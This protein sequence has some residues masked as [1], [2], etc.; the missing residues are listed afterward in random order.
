MKIREQL[1]E[2]EIRILSKHATLSMNSKGREREEK[3]CDIRPCF[4]RD[5]DRILYSKSFRRLKDKTQV[6]LSPDGDHYRTRM[7]HTLEVSQ[8]ARTI[9]KALM[10]NE[11]LAEAIA[12]GHDL[13]HT[14]FGHAGERA[15][16][17]VNPGGFRHNEQSL[18]IVE[19]LEN[20]G[21]GLNLTWEVRDGILNHEMNLTPGTLEGKVVR[22]S[23]K[24]AYMHHDMDDAI[25]G[26]ILSEEDVPADLRRVI[27]ESKREWLDTFIHDIISNSMEKDNIQMSD[28]IYDAFHKLRKFMFERVYTNPIAKSQ[29][30]KVEDMIKTLYSYYLDH[31]DKIPEYLKKM[32]DEGESKE[33]AVCDYV[34]SMTDRYAVAVFEE[35]YVPRS[36]G[37]L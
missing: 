14:P 8:N 21:I 12:L 22:L 32:M 4:Q 24:I 23:D 10:L 5:R 11:D 28:E 1:E 6:F 35:I 19:K 15:L 31:I 36:W 16:N 7:T 9:A 2:R 37:V 34:S 29:E 33:R 27:G 17:D 20:Y 30:G 3:P 26:G 18:R 13:G 25:R